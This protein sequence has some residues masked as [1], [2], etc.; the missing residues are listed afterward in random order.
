MPLT[1]CGTAGVG[2]GNRRSRVLLRGRGRELETWAEAGSRPTGAAECGFR[3]AV[4]TRR[5]RTAW[6][7]PARRG[8]CRRCP[9]LGHVRR[10]SV[11]RLRLFRLP[12]LEEAEHVRIGDIGRERVL[13]ASL[14]RP[15]R[16]HQRSGCRNGP[17]TLVGTNRQPAADHDHECLLGRK[18]PTSARGHYRQI[19]PTTVQHQP[20]RP[21]RSGRTMSH[22]FTNDSDYA[23]FCDSRG[24]ETWA[25]LEPPY[26]VALDLAWQSALRGQS[27]HRCGRSR[28][29]TARWWRRDGTV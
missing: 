2:L 3:R 16:G 25:E 20:A 11:R 19:P 28:M 7:W 12:D 23:P 9:E 14:L 17:I 8:P 27:R 29:R 18:S 4:T 26:R 21:F 24:G 15:R 22:E 1:R 13:R 6:R 10:L 5:P